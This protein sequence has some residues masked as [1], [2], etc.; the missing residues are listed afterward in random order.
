MALTPIDVQQKTFA[1]ALRGYDLDEVDDFLDSV[2]VAL[3]DYDQRLTDAQER[4][5]TLQAEL[6]DRGDAE[7]A[8]ARA[9]VAAQR[10]ADGILADAR[11]EADRIVADA[12]NEA[13]ELAGE[14]DRE[15]QKLRDEISA[16]RAKIVEVRSSVAELAAAIP[17]T[18]DDMDAALEDHEEPA[19]GATFDAAQ[20]VGGYEIASDEEDL[21][22]EE[23]LDVP[24]DDVSVDDVPGRLTTSRHLADASEITGVEYVDLDGAD[25]DAR[26]LLE[27]DRV[28]APSSAFSVEELSDQIDDAFDD[29]V[30]ETGDSA[31][32]AHRPWEDD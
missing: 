4:I 29:I 16:I 2:V 11:E 3:K 6:S 27:N 9:L 8:I 28:S 32:T 12:N 10:S 19:V 25:A 22:V 1:T 24:V 18:L 14:R 23:D 7:G 31:E 13:S 17:A 21:E 15:Q 20:P 26:G 5:S 30:S